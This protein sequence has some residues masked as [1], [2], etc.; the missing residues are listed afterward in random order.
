MAYHDKNKAFTLA[1]VLIT[2]GIIGVVAAL[3][4]PS[5]ITKYKRHELE[6]RFKK[7]SAIVENALNETAHELSVEYL[8][9]QELN[10]KYVNATIPDEERN[11]INNSFVSKLKVGHALVLKTFSEGAD[12]ISDKVNQQKIYTYK[13]KQEAA[14]YYIFNHFSTSYLLADGTTVSTI[15]FQTHGPGDGLKVYID[16]NGPFKGPNRYGYDIFIYDSGSW[17]RVSCNDQYFYG[18]YD[19]AKADQNPDDDTKGYWDSL[20][21]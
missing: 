8:L 6:N 21:F 10:S 17:S 3:T 11:Q 12:A 18:C 1:E 9:K 2:L 19:Y 7:T 14:P 16:T 5:F 13:S 20:E 15:H 4:L